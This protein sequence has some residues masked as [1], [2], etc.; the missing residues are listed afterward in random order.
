MS[1]RHSSSCFSRQYVRFAGLREPR[2]S[3][4]SFAEDAGFSR[5]NYRARG[6]I[7]VVTRMIPGADPPNAHGASSSPPSSARRDHAL[8]CRAAAREPSSTRSSIRGGATSPQG[9][10]GEWRRCDSPRTWN[11]SALHSYRFPCRPPGYENV[12][13]IRAQNSL[14]TLRRS[15]EF[16]SGR[17]YSYEVARR[18]R[19]PG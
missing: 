19:K 9:W 4:I 10:E 3:A 17:I 7:D 16:P 11:S 2:K 5:P 13:T 15:G 8:G 1:A 18:R 6:V 12:A 14:D